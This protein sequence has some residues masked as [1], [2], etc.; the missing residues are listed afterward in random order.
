MEFMDER[1]RW[2]HGVLSHELA[3]SLVQAAITLL[4]MD[5]AGEDAAI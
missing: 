1:S 5:D 2:E 3:Q 4:D